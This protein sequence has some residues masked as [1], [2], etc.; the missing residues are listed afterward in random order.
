M[1]RTVAPIA[2][3]LL[4]DEVVKRLRAMIDDGLLAPGSRIPERQLCAQLGIS[5]TPLREAYRVLAAEGLVELHPH[6]ATRVA[7]LKAG[8]VDPIFQ[9]MEALEALA[10]ELACEHIAEEE[11]Q[12]I[13][14]LHERMLGHYRRRRKT[15]F[16]LL[17]QEIHERI[18]RASANP[19]L[20]RVYGSLSG[21]MRRARF[22]S[23]NTEAQWREAVREHE[24][25]MQALAARDRTALPRLLRAHLRSKRDKVKALLAEQPA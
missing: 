14:R 13:R 8:E 16:F 6:R 4:L 23:L 18:L 15:G 10:G 9:V 1:D 12:D 17:N 24:A 11:I 25:I 7:K 2:R 3:P 21:R 22:M 19:V 20:I 5:R